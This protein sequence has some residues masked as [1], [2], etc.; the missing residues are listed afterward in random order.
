MKSRIAVGLGLALGA[1]ILTYGA[2][3]SWTGYIS[4]SHCAAK[5]AKAGHE[6]C[7]AKCVKDGA[8]YV[9]VDDASK[10]VFTVD[11]ADKVA[12]HAGHHVTV[13]GSVDGDTLKV[14]SVE[15]AK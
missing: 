9:F 10:K 13:K 3:G 1:A 5:G 2:D 12:A 11:P 4:D 8:K 7:A 14:S 15:M 6:E